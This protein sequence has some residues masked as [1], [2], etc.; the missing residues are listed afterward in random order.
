MSLCDVSSAEA[1]LFEE[2]KIQIIN[3]WQLSCVALNRSVSRQM[4]A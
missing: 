2:Q 1:F 4:A 3:I